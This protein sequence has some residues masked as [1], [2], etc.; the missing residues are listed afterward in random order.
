MDFVVIHVR[1]NNFCFGNSWWINIVKILISN[2]KKKKKK[3]ILVAK[4]LQNI[5]GKK[6]S[7]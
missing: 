2:K 1:Q 4:E 5:T 3:V 6:Y 7:P